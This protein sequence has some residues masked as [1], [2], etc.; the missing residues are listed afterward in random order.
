MPNKTRREGIKRGLSVFLAVMLALTLYIPLAPV[1]NAIETPDHV[2]ISMV[3][4]GGGNTDARYKNDF[5]ELYNPTDQEV[6]ISGWTIQYAGPTTNSFSTSSSLYTVIPDTT[7]IQSHGYYLIQEAAGTNGSA[8]DLP[9]TP[10][11]TGSIA[12]GATA[13]K[14]ALIHGTP[15][16]DPFSANLIDFIGYGNTANQCEGTTAAA[17]TNTSAAVRKAINASGNAIT[18]EAGRTGNGYDSNDNGADFIVVDQGQSSFAI[19]NAQSPTEPVGGGGGTPGTTFAVLS[20]T[21]MH[22]KCWDTN[23]LTNQP[24]GN[25]MLKV[26]TAVYDIRQDIRE[27]NVLLIDNGDVYQGTPVSAYHIAQDTSGNAVGPNPMALSMKYIGYDANVLGNHEFNYDWN[28]MNHIYDYLQAD[29]EYDPVPVLAANLYWDGTDGISG[30]DAGANAFTPYITKDIDVDGQTLKIGILGLEN[31]DCPRWDVPDNYPGITF[32]TDSAIEVQ[33]YVSKM[34]TEDGCD[35]IILSYHSGMGT[36]T[37]ALQYG[38]NTENQ[39]AR[40]IENTTG[41]AIVIAGHDHSTGYSNHT[42]KNKNNDNVLVVNA[43][44]TELTKSIFSATLNPDNSISVE[45]DNSQ[46]VNL[47]SYTG[48]NEAKTYAQTLKTMIAPY[49]DAASEY[50]NQPVGTLTG[51]WDTVT[52]HYLRQSDTIDLINRAQIAEGSKYM[53]EKYPEGVTRSALFTD[54]GLDHITVD[55]SSTS[56]VVDGNYTATAGALSMRDIYRMY[57]YDNT[58]YLLPLTGQQIKDILE[59]NAQYRLSVSI[60]G[61]TAHY[62][63]IGD[64]FTNP[65]FYGLNFQYDMA[66]SVGHRAIITGFS[67]GTAFD[68]NKE[69][70]MAVNNYHLGNGPFAAY[71]TDDTIW[72]QTDDLESGVVQDLIAEYVADE[73]VAHGGVSP[74]HGANYPNWSLTYSGSLE[75]NLADTAYIACATTAALTTGDKVIIYHNAGGTV[76]STTVTGNPGSTKLSPVTVTVNG[77]VLYANSSAAAFS[78][79][80]DSTTGYY[81]FTSNGK[82]LTSGPTGNSLDLTTAPGANDLSSWEVTTTTGG[83][84]IRNVGAAFNG[85]HNQYLEYYSGFTTYGYP[86]SSGSA[87]YIYSFYKVVPTADLMTAAPTDGDQFVIWYDSGKQIVGTTPLS[88]KLAPVDSSVIGTQLLVP[89]GSAVAVFTAQLDSGT[90]YYYYITD[91]GKYLTSGAGGNELSLTTLPDPADATNPISCSL[92]EPIAVTGGWH[93]RNAGALFSG[94]A[95]QGLEFYGGGFT[96]YGLDGSSKFTYNF[97]KFN[98]YTPELPVSESGKVDDLIVNVGADTSKLNF[99]WYCADTVSGKPSVKVKGV[100]TAFTG[101]QG[102]AEPGKKWNKVTVLGLIPGTEYTVQISSDGTTY[103]GPYTFKTPASDKFTF[104]AVGDP[105]IGCSESSAAIDTDATIE[106]TS[107]AWNTTVK[108]IVSKG[109]VFIAGTGDQIENAKQGATNIA[110]KQK[111]YTGF[112]AG[113]TQS[114]RIIP[115]ASVMGN[116]EADGSMTSGDGRDMYGYHY[117]RPNAQTEVVNG[118]QLSN[119]YYLYNNILFVVLDTAPY[120]KTTD[121]SKY[122]E[123][124]PEAKQYIAAFDKVLGKATAANAGKYDWLVVQTHKNQQSNASHWN[125]ADIKA[126]SAAGFEDLMTK[127]DVDLALTGHDHSYTRTFPFKSNYTTVGTGGPLVTN[128]ITIDQNNQENTLVDPDGTVYMAL[129]SSTGSKY[130]AIQST[131]KA[132]TKVQYQANKPEYTM[133]EAENGKLTITTYEV[134]AATPIDSFTITK[135]ENS[136]RVDD[137]IVNVGADASKLN[138]NWYC[139]TAVSGTP[140]VKVDGVEAAFTGTQGP[141][142]TGKKWNQVTV[143]G[144]APDTE[145]TAQIS[146]DGTTYSMSYTFK[147]AGSGKF[148]FA[149]VGDPQLGTSEPLD[150]D[151]SI[152]ADALAWDTTVKEIVSK[153]ADF[154]AG[155]GDQIENIAQGAANIAIKKKEYTGFADG[156]TQGSRIIPFSSVMGNHEADG[157]AVSGDGRNMY[158]YHYNRPNLETAVVSGFQLNNYY[159]LYNNI[160][161]VVLDTAPYPKSAAEAKPYIDTFDNVLGKATTASAGKYNWLVVQT[162][163]SQ[164]SNASHFNDSDIKAYSAAG[165]EDLMTKYDVDL[166]LTGHDHSYTRTFPFKSNYTTV[167][168]GGP[169]VTN[170]ITIDQNNQESTLL[171]PDGTVYM[172]LNSS[173]GSKY[174]AIQPTKK[175]TSKIDYQAN[176]PEYTIIEAEGRALTITTYE[177]SAATAIDSFTMTKSTPPPPSPDPDN[178]DDDDDSPSGGSAAQNPPATNVPVITTATDPAT[179]AVMTT[180]VWPDGAREVKIELS[181]SATSSNKTVVHVPVPNAGPGTIAVLVKSDGTEEI[182]RTSVAQNGELLVPLGASGTVKIIEA[183]QSFPDT[184]K[185]WASDSVAFVTARGLFSGTSGSSFSPDTSMTRGMLVTVLHRL[186]NT[187]AGGTQSFA[188]VPP[189]QYY[190]DAVAWASQQGIVE[191]TNTGFQP[192]A[193]IT[194]EQL[195]V[196]LYRYAAPGQASGSLGN[197]PDNG[198]VSSWASEAM[199][200]AVGIG[201]FSGDNSGKLN[202]GGNAT[203]AE[204]AV[205]LQRFI[206]NTTI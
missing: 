33:H 3:Y 147:T 158:G 187:P 37:G 97:Y 41:V 115:F 89:T 50:V 68:L 194:R 56:V 78:V 134:S 94:Q 145:Y 47:T 181:T 170:G 137:L 155:T 148:T 2:V 136:K 7:M 192:D 8:E 206:T 76:L 87:P 31:P 128:G 69:Y 114:G 18:P 172:T 80:K 173:T 182:I 54:T 151:L 138:F 105:Q 92:W 202:P 162:H 12:M 119:Y 118:F 131:K 165:F 100:S 19:H 24:A 143:T 58:L 121:P 29:N 111:E 48:T 5:V 20:T 116:H 15:V 124:V 140:S 161:F 160:L 90:G 51:T 91:D 126:Y 108:E 55:M 46:N 109:A 95:N 175:A 72:S 113:L 163:K 199:R 120:M 98:G 150:S 200:W 112:A 44:G 85:N 141:A 164:Q 184:D 183:G 205:I 197:F 34:R 30:H 23:L 149:A 157:S 167:G 86:S 196:I 22:G 65:I 4:G 73:T 188:D 133:I 39:I 144:L 93:V 62:S 110:I 139:D 102:T 146:S 186:E 11:A 142:E 25:S 35:F 63:T 168:T 127:Y 156:L 49:A 122:L 36:T 201:L 67:N 132:T 204:V 83:V 177:V 190:A 179:G 1:A 10:D 154:I 13:G 169:L 60:S 53:A 130:Y 96:T 66:Q 45:L 17:L 64:D 70:I 32:A 153:G 79:N 125:D 88:G 123:N 106:A 166:A 159:Y 99:N 27:D 38:V 9:V 43:G 129:N 174:Y 82:Y 152:D 61:G 14:V 203:R 107:I 42:Y 40:V 193:D 28:A 104:A 101:T 77:S 81:T 71:S 176:K 185:H 195:A 75:D 189:G 178:D 59:Y 57:K 135:P 74:S 21:D 171:D 191:G 16:T 84:L 52:N 117:N 103:S 198:D 6:D 180:T 26:A